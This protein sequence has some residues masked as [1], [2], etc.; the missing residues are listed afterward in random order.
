MTAAGIRAMCRSFD[1]AGLRPDRIRFL[2]FLSGVSS[3]IRM[4]RQVGFGTVSP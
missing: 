2:K 3:V 4:R 1:L